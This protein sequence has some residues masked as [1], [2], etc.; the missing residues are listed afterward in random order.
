MR[1]SSANKSRVR[2]SQ[3]EMAKRTR[4]RKKKK[5]KKSDQDNH[6]IGASPDLQIQG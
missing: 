2:S 5:R 3:V 6:A 4:R 1:C